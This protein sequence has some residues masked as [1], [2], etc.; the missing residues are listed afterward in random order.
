[1]LGDPFEWVSLAGNSTPVNAIA[2]A[3]PGFDLLDAIGNALR[4]ELIFPAT[5]VAIPLLFFAGGGERATLSIGFSLLIILS[6]LYSIIGAAI[7]GSVDTIELS[8]ALPG[9]L[10]GIAGFAWVYL[11]GMRGIA[12]VGLVVLSVIAL[13]LAWWQM[14]SYPHQNLEQA[15][16]RAISTGEDQ[17][18]TG[19]RGG[20]Q[21]GIAPESEMASSSTISRSPRTRS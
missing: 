16:T 4:I 20:Y 18:G 15:F 2:S 7:Q 9:M 8:D 14:E 3:S 12:M 13:P 19:S 21:V 6:I 10:A 5:L 17:E 11:N 1:M